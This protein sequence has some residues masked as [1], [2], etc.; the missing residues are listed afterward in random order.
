MK[1]LD[2]FR[3]IIDDWDSSEWEYFFVI[4]GKILDIERLISVVKFVLEF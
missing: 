4:D 3:G 2:K 1:G